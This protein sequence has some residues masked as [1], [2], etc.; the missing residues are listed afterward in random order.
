MAVFKVNAAQLRECLAEDL[1]VNLTPMV[2]SSPGMGKSDVIRQLAKDFNLKVIDIRTSQREPVDMN[3]YPD[4]KDDRMVVNVPEELPIEGDTIPEGYDGWLIFFDEFNSG[5]K[6]TEAACYRVILDREVGKHKLHK[7]CRIVCAGNLA[8][9]RAITTPQGTAMMSRLIHYT[10]QIDD[11]MWIEWANANGIDHRIVSFIKFSPSSLHRFDPQKNDDTFPCPRTWE[12]ASKIISGKET[13]STITKIR[14]AG[15]VGEG[16]AAEL[17]TFAEIYKDLPTIEDILKNPKSGW[18]VP[19]EP[20]RQYAVTTMLSHNIT[21]ENIE[22]IVTATGR[23]PMDFQVITFKDVY[24]KAPH[25]KK[26]A[27]IRKWIADNASVMFT[28]CLFVQSAGAA[29]TEIL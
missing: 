23:L 19:T 4:S 17:S 3:G 2:V 1:R 13:I 24:K 6:Q 27:V 20:S 25:L 15:A 8:T 26:H 29:F 16:A 7:N 9:D 18:K 21:E 5:T 11:N 10:M 22:D 28:L 14:L 12:F